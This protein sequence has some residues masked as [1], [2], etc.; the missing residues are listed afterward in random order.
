MTNIKTYIDSGILQAYVLGTASPDEIVNVESAVSMY[1]EVKEALEMF[2]LELEQYYLA[3]AQTPDP[4]IKPMVMAS[5]DLMQRLENGE[6]LKSVP[7]LNESS[8]VEDYKEWLDRSDLQSKGSDDVSAKIIGYTPT[9]TT[10]I[11]WLK[12]MAPEEVHHNEYERFLI[13]EGTCEI[14]IEDKVY[15]LRAGDYLQIPLHVHHSVKVTS[16]VPCKAILQR[17][18]A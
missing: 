10:A 12:D 14:T 7:L 9:A 15:P 2:E 13:L 1:P 6:E 3:N 16:S 18:A 11:I 17:V 4:T 5:I 8:K